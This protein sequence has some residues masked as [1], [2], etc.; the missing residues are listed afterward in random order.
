MI[1]G[2]KL[3][4]YFERCENEKKPITAEVF[5]TDYCNLKCSYCRYANSSGRYIRYQDF[6]RYAERLLD[7]SVRGIILT[8]GG[9]PTIN[10][11][12]KKIAKWLETNGI[13]YGVNTNLLKPLEI[14]PVFLKVS[15][16]TGNEATYNMI[17]GRNML[18]TVLENLARVI[19]FR[20]KSRAKTKIGVQC[21]ATDRDNVLSFYEC[22]KRFDVDYIYIRPYEGHNDCYRVGAAEVKEW[23]NGVSDNR[24]NVSFKF[25]LIDYSPSLCLGNWAVITV[26]VDGNVPYC[27][28]LPNEIVG[29]IL[30]KDIMRR[31]ATYNVN[32]AKCDRPCRMSGINNYL[33]SHE[34]EHDIYFV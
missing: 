4:Y 14:S 15:I 29:H 26:D 2:N 17:R 34:K 12:F 3:Q 20:D 9:E 5:L 25:D 28:H 23:L 19:E 22:V 10:P 24:I 1:T 18:C 8:G 16:D 13:H 33:E 11:D 30:D 27:C 31:K 7:M 6:I 21:V 32:M